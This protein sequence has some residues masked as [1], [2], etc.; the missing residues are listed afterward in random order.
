MALIT[1][2][3]ITEE[4]VAGSLNTSAAGGDEFVN[5]GVEFIRISNG[6][7][8]A[9][10]TVTITA[11]TTTYSFP[12]HGK[13]TK[14]NTTINIGAANS[15]FIG[16]FKPTVWSDADGKVQ[17]T[18]KLTSNNSAITGTHLLKTEVLYLEQK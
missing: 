8:S 4:A 1:P 13:L 2:I 15:V 12:R 14:P 6:H 18:Y 10:Y 11:Q 17:I 3:K 16:P 5:S 9:Q 7:A